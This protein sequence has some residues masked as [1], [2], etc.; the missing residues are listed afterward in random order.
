MTKKDEYFE[1]HLKGK[2]NISHGRQIKKETDLCLEALNGA[3]LLPAKQV[4]DGGY[5]FVIFVGDSLAREAAW[6]MRRLADSNLNQCQPWPLTYDGDTKSDPS[7][8]CDNE[9]QQSNINGL[10]CEGHTKPIDAIPQS[11]CSQPFVLFKRMNI[12]ENMEQFMND[13]VNTNCKCRGIIY[14]QSALH[15]MLRGKQEQIFGGIDGRGNW[16][17]N[18]LSCW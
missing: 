13:V 10:S 3:Q 17:Y 8:I 9:E 12:L 5:N 1:T 4:T 2:L 18:L 16:T 15:F 11:C 14:M 7:F 6:S